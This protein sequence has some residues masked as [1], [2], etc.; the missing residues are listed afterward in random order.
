[1][2]N[3][4]LSNRSKRM[5]HFKGLHSR[6]GLNL[7]SL[8]DIFTILVF[9]LLVSTGAPQLPNSK[10]IT[11]PTSVAKNVPKET[12]IVTITKTDV[13]VQG[14]K[15][16]AISDLLND[17]EA[18]IGD[19]EKE[20]KFLASKRQFTESDKKSGRAITIMGDENIP[21]Q[22]LRK[23]LATCRQANYTTIAFAA[24]QKAKKG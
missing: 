22:L 21:Y 1:M 7:V 5:D 23:I 4:K 13:L 6:S 16:A 2:N 10:D 20:L 24:F 8:M 18:I 17:K 11:L 12:L 3:L 9:F 15:V 14:K 19:L